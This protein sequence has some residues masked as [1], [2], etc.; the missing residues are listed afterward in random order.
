MLVLPDHLT[1]AE[2]VR[3]LVR[4]YLFEFLTRAYQYYDIAIWS[5]TSMT[6]ILAKIS[7]MNLISQ[8]TANRVRQRQVDL[9]SQDNTED[10]Q[11]V[12]NICADIEV[13]GQPFQISLLVDAGAM[14]SVHL[15]ERGCVKEVRCSFVKF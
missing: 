11:N 14:I 4:P 13:T 10:S 6:W 7:Q 3:H 5:A 15:P 9:A 12:P 1:P 8:T 2:S